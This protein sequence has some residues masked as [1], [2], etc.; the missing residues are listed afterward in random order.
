CA[1]S[2]GAACKRA[3]LPVFR[4]CSFRIPRASPSL[5]PTHSF[6]PHM[7]IKPRPTHAS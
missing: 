5:P 2:T 1:A 6:I 4:G 3:T 7:L